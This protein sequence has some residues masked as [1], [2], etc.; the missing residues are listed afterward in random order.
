[1]VA[2][3][4]KY[5]P[6]TFRQL[7]AGQ[8]FEVGK[9]FLLSG[10]NYL[11]GQPFDR[12]CVSERLLAQLYRGRNLVAVDHTPLAN[13]PALVFQVKHLGFGK[14]CVTGADGDPVT[15]PTD[16]ASARLALAALQEG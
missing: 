10:R 2:R 1:M 9:P 6:P 5:F 4:F 15:P 3:R 12:S 8:A 14:Y 7:P 11:P 13:D 16:K